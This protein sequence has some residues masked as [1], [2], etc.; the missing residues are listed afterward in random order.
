MQRYAFTNIVIVAMSVSWMFHG[1]LTAGAT[2]DAHT[3]THNDTQSISENRIKEKQEMFQHWMAVSRW[4]WRITQGVTVA[5]LASIAYMTYRNNS[6]AI[7]RNDAQ[8]D[9][10]QACTSEVSHMQGRI[11]NLQ[12]QVQGLGRQLQE[13]RKHTKMQNYTA[14]HES[15]GGWLSWSSWKPTLRTCG[16]VAIDTIRDGTYRAFFAGIAMAPVALYRNLV[17]PIYATD[18]SLF[19]SSYTTLNQ[20]LMRMSVI[21]QN[22]FAQFQNDRE[23]LTNM[24]VADIESILAFL[25]CAQ[26]YMSQDLYERIGWVHDDIRMQAEHFLNNVVSDDRGAVITAIQ[27]LQTQIQTETSIYQRII[28]QQ[29]VC[30]WITTL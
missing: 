6:E 26:T 3:V 21:V 17:R 24:L 5:T 25:R 19:I 23:Y 1:P 30:S 2:A 8:E 13:L 15:N 28:A 12:A 14:S 22:Q 10:N 7:P 16:H 29:D 27:R 9:D 20:L 4:T 18:M 11:D